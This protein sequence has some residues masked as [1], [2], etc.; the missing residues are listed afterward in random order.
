ML[1]SDDDEIGLSPVKNLETTREVRDDDFVDMLTKFCSFYTFYE[2]RPHR[3]NQ[4]IFI[5]DRNAGQRDACFNRSKG[6]AELIS[7]TPTRAG[8][9]LRKDLIKG[10]YAH[11]EELDLGR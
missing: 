11:L 4:L 3:I 6:I 7:P 8:G 5:E 9:L 1:Q 2:H 10:K